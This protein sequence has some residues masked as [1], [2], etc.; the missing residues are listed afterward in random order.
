MFAWGVPTGEEGTASLAT[1]PF[2]F[3]WTGPPPRSS[4]GAMVAAREVERA[5][6]DLI[7]ENEPDPASSAAVAQLVTPYHQNGTFA[8]GVRRSP[9][10]P[11]FLRGESGGFTD[12]ART[13]T[14]T[15]LVRMLYAH[16]LPPGISSQP[17]ADI[18]GVVAAALQFS[19]SR[20]PICD[21]IP[22]QNY[23]DYVRRAV[24]LY[25]FRDPDVE[26]NTEEDYTEFVVEAGLRIIGSHLPP[27]GDSTPEVLRTLMAVSLLAGAIA[28]DLKC[29][30]CAASVLTSDNAAA[31]HGEPAASRSEAIYQWL[32]G[33]LSDQRLFCRELFEW[34][35]YF[36]QVLTRDC[37][38]AFFPDDIG[39]TLFDLYRLQAEM[40]YN[41]QL[42]VILV[43]R[44]GRFHND[45][46]IADAEALL[47]HDRFATL[48]GFREEGRFVVNTHGPRNGAIDPRRISRRLADTLLGEVDVLFAKG[49]RSYEMIA[50]GIRMPTFAGQTV[51]REFSESVTGASAA[52]GVPVLRFMHVFPDYWGF[53]DRHRRTAAL[54]PDDRPGWQARMTALDSAR[55]TASPLFQATCRRLGREAASLEIM[56]RAAEAGVAPHDVAATLG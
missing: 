1:H 40:L 23:I 31:S 45:C 36:E 11:P 44:N 8:I 39:E 33:K 12:W 48:R 26:F 55:F 9:S 16:A 47:T 38:L 14:R 50:T 21:E 20:G 49:S 42:R 34:D 5:A 7:L 24:A 22:N 54:Y 28:L 52:C 10:T 17:F 32:T 30:H 56:S 51:T 2:A 13:V 29:S 15:D 37:T 27:P 46:G 19:G 3:L 6:A 35:R 4:H 18:A 25:L 53:T 43:P 41:P